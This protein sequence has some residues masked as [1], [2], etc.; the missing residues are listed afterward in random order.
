MQGV[1]DGTVFMRKQRHPPVAKS[2]S[3]TGESFDFLD[4]R[5]LYLYLSCAI[6][7]DADAQDAEKRR[8]VKSA[9]I[10][11]EVFRAFIQWHIFR[12]LKQQRKG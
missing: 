11:R 3:A 9:G 12:Q 5:F 4:Q 7:F 6:V 2:K 8:H 1:S 10:P